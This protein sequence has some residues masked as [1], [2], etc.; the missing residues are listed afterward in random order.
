MKHCIINL[1]YNDLIFLKHKLPFYYKY[2]SQII[3]VDY[4]IVYGGNSNDGSI[5]YIK[6][7]NDPENKI[8]LLTNFNEI[9]DSISFSYEESGLLKEEQQMMVSCL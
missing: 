2:F 3:F 9:K 6:N 7:Y 8:I 5:E 1:P 4:D